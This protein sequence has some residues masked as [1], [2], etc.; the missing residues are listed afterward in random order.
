MHFG[1]CLFWLHTLSCLGFVSLADS[2]CFLPSSGRRRPF[3]SENDGVSLII[4]SLSAPPCVAVQINT[5]VAVPASSRATKSSLMLGL[6]LL[7]CMAA[8]VLG[9]SAN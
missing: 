2:F 4:K 5:R 8:V 3:V 1:R 6:L 7:F 9:S